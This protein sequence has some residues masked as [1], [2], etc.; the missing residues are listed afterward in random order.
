MRL[1]SNNPLIYPIIHGN[2]L[3]NLRDVAIL[4]EGIQISLSLA[5]T[6]ALKK[7]NI[8][9]ANPPIAA[10]SHFPYLSIEYWSCAVTQDTGPE[11]HQAGSCKMGPPNDPMAVV[12]PELRVYGIKGLRVADTSIMPKVIVKFNKSITS[13]TMLYKLFEFSTI[14]REIDNK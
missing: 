2:Y 12:D 10:C 9:L 4:V 14:L 6:T 7:Y 3:T 13:S 1:A 8:T 11:N 5:N